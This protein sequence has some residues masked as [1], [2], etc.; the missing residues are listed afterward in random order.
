MCSYWL[1]SFWFGRDSAASAGK[2]AFLYNRLAD[3]GFLIAIF[4]VF[5]KTGTLNYTGIFSHLSQHRRRDGHGHLPAAVRGRR[6]QV[7]PAPAVPVVGRR[8]GGP[9]TGVRP[10]PR[11]HHGHGRR[12]PDV[13]DQPAAGPVARR[14]AGGGVGRGRHRLRGRHHRVRPAGHQ[15]GARLLDGV[16][17]RLHVPGRGHRRLRGG[18]LP[19]G[20]P[21]LL[22]GPAVP[23]GRVGH[24]RAARRAGPQDAWG[25]CAAT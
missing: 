12:L 22:Q 5:S 18:H 15:E 6:R 23:R 10:H 13:P 4:L 21:R 7:G 14:P 17:A 1:V 20:G 2:K 9:H 3:V 25:T 8:H 11:R 16:A 19:H 24:P